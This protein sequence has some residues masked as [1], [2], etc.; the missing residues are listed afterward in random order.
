MS[1]KVVIVGGVAGGASTAAR[2]RRVDEDAEIIM[3]ERGEHISFANCGLPY[4]IGEIIEERSK[5]LVQT[6][7]AMRKRFKIDVRVFN[8]VVSIDRENKT[9]EIK[10]LKTQETYTESY[11]I[12]VLSPGANPIAPPIRGIDHPNIFT[13]RNIPDTDTIKE[14]VD[15]QKPSSATVVGGGFIGLEMAE[16][17]HH[18]GIDVTIVEMA[19]Q[20]M[21]PIDYEMAALVHEH[22]RS[23]NVNLI[24]KDGVKEFADNKGQVKVTLRSGLLIETDMVIMAIGVKPDTTLA[25]DCGLELGDR[26]GIKVNEYLQT[27]DPSIYAIGDAIEVEDFVTGKNT[28]IPLAGPANK[29]GRIAAN[30]IAGKTE[31]YKK[32]QGTAIAKVF[33]LAVAST[34]VNEKTLKQDGIKYIA[35]ITH[36]ASHAGYYPGAIPLSIKILFTPKGKLLGAQIVG[37]NGIDKRIDVLATCLRFGKT[38]FDLQELELAYAPPFSSAKDPVN[39]AG[40]VAG[41]IINGDTDIVHWHEIIDADLT[42]VQL[43]DVRTQ[44]EWDLGTIEGAI[45]IPLDEMRDRLNELPK[46]KELIIFCQVGLRGYLA[47]RILKQNGFTG[48]K[49][50][51]GGCK[52]YQPVYKEINHDKS[53]IDS[54]PCGNNN[55]VA[56]CIGNPTIKSEVKTVPTKNIVKLDACGLQCPGPIMQVFQKMQTLEAGQILEVRATDPGFVSDIPVWCQRTGNNLVKQEKEGNC[57]IAYIQK[58]SDSKAAVSPVETVTNSPQDKTLVVFSGDLDK[59]IASFI[60][61]NGAASMGRKV[62]M[63]FTFW[64]LNILRKN[65]KVKTKKA[66][67]DKMFGMMMPK[68]SKKL[69]LS[70]MNML[71]MGPKMIRFVMTNKNVDSL[72]TLIEQAKLAGIRLVACQ[73]SMDVMGIKKE[74][75][76]E[77]V[78][79]GGVASYLGAAEES[80]VNL[81]I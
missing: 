65:S 39:M 70:N 40:Y 15:N 12:L 77:G 2:L 32:T 49:N 4:H 63:F 36:S 19:D 28:L 17:L 24:L 46:D 6:P 79:V 37:Y 56:D 57:F 54:I 23:K 33:D 18:R 78:E 5:L 42:K 45:H 74:E 43:V 30:N 27:S 53:Y 22:I 66:F 81:F 48:V 44:L 25:K 73:M 13:L 11:D 60:I 50:L 61:A 34:G 55:Q 62:T 52:T 80:N 31:A 35:S 67:L 14:F 8:E 59:A 75:L 51:S 68:G 20:V 9:V 3:L 7:D 69:K 76:I 47:T 16:N 10:N 38:V 21:G 29:Q 1:R 64:G 26:G 41:N 71:G 72:E 58:G